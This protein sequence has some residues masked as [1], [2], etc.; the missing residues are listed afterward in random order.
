M[1]K[2]NPERFMQK[3]EIMNILFVCTGNTCRSCMAEV[4]A[5]NLI[6]GSALEVEF[7]SAGIYAN[8]GQ[9]ASEG[10]TR[11]MGEMGLDLS[12]HFAKTVTP[13]LV[14]KADIILALTIGHKNLIVSRYP[15]A[16]QKTFT[17]L[18]YIGEVGDIEDPFGGDVIVYRNCANTIKSSIEKLLLILKES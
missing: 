12:K 4:L 1:I 7:S 10:A 9:N 5:N 2:K 18:E 6:N 13:E 16:R 3:E 14:H 11:V 15:E 8:M 17:L